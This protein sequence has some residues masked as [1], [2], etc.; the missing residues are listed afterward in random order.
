MERKISYFE[1]KFEWDCFPSCVKMIL[2]YHLGKPQPFTQEDIMD[3]CNTDKNGTS[4]SDVL[5]FLKFVGLPHENIAKKHWRYALAHFL[6]NRSPMMV[7]YDLR[8]GDHHAAVLIG[9][10]INKEIMIVHDPYYGQYLQFPQYILLHHLK[11]FIYLD[12][13]P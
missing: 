8:D 10:D 1:Q 9:W 3:W 2:D 4:T 12:V 11:E 5:K 6:I 13:S 7:T